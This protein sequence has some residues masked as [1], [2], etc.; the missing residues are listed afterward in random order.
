MTEEQLLRALERLALALF[1]APAA[2]PFLRRYGRPVM[3][4]A[5][6]V[7]IVA[8]GAALVLTALYF[9]GGA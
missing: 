6:T 7:Y 2:F 9:L 3:I 4:L 5:V 8:L 1:I